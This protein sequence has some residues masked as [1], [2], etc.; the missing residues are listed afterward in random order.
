MS[1][2]ILNLS[3]I[4][5]IFIFIALDGHSNDLK[6]LDIDPGDYIALPG[7]S[8]LALG[9]TR[10]AHYDRL[11]LKGSGNVPQSRLNSETAILAYVHYFDIDGLTVN[12]RI[13]IPFS[14]LDNGQ[15]GG[16]RLNDAMGLGD[17]FVAA[18]A[19]LIN[20]P[21]HNRYF[22]VSSYFFLPLGHY[23]KNQ[24]LNIGENRWKSVYQFGLTE[25]ITPKI[26]FEVVA[27]VTFYGDNTEAGSGTQKLSQDHSYQLQPWVRYAISPTSV[28]SLGYSGRFSGDQRL[29][30]A[31]TGFTAGAHAVRIDYRSFITDKLQLAATVSRDIDVEGGFQE[32]FRLNLRI[33]KMF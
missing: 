18:T 27:D 31:L 14:R 20:Q 15:S 3:L 33:L 4:F 13:F 29:D 32:A 28:L 30:G 21:E 22:G 2:P 8:D 7:G 24:A 1:K 26:T 12:P 10:F 16:S 5:Q 6:A 19:W 9:Y 17:P 11:I 23:N 25:G